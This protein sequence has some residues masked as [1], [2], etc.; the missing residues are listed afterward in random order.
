MKMEYRRDVNSSTHCSWFDIFISRELT[1][2]SISHMSVFTCCGHCCNCTSHH[3]RP[4]HHGGDHTPIS[5]CPRQPNSLQLSVKC[6]LMHW[7]HKNTSYFWLHLWPSYRTLG[8]QSW[9]HIGLPGNVWV[10][11]ILNFSGL[12]QQICPAVCFV[13]MFSAVYLFSIFSIFNSYSEK[14]L[15]LNHHWLDPFQLASY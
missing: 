4:I 12:K 6:C 10:M 3:C 11:D 5:C 2:M 7:S 1:H 9:V 8:A 15:H 13:T 14:R